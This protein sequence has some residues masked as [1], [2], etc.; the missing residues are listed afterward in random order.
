VTWH[1]GLKVRGCFGI[2]KGTVIATF[3][4]GRYLSHPT[5]NHAAFYIGQDATGIV[6]V[7]QWTTSGS[8]RKRRI[9]FMGKDKGGSFIT[10][11]NNADAFS[12]VE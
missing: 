7:D 10:P 6:I 8:I 1:E 2:K 12:V 5:G 4:N 11:S 9:A 3:V